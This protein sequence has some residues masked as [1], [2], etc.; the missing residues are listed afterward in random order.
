MSA[1][2]A[3]S[4]VGSASRQAC[5]ACQHLFGAGA[6]NAAGAVAGQLQARLLAQVL[7]PFPDPGRPLRL[8]L[9]FERDPAGR[10]DL[11]QGSVPSL[12]RRGLQRRVQRLF[13]GVEVHVQGDGRVGP[14]LA[15]VGTQQAGGVRRRALSAPSRAIDRAL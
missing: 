15:R 2:A 14:D 7:D 4:S 8:R 5:Q 9:V 11:N 3:S 12:A 1:A 13:V 10:E 6:A